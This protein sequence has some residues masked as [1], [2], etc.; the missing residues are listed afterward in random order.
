MPRRAYILD[1]TELFLLQL[2]T[3]TDVKKETLTA[4]ATEVQIKTYMQ[5]RLV[6]T[7]KVWVST[8]IVD[9]VNFARLFEIA[10]TNLFG[11]PL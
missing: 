9:K 11:R 6:P 1:L 3:V 4:T 2:K 10:E 5:T 8:E 7:T